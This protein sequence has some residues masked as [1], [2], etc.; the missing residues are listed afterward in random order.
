MSRIRVPRTRMSSLCSDA[1]PRF[2]QAAVGHFTHMTRGKSARIPAAGNNIAENQR[3]DFMARD[4]HKEA[5]AWCGESAAGYC[6]HPRGCAGQ[7]PRPKKPGR[8]AACTA[9]VRYYRG[10]LNRNAGKAVVRNRALH[11]VFFSLATINLA[12]GLAHSKWHLG[13]GLACIEVDLPS[14]RGDRTSRLRARTCARAVAAV[15]EWWWFP[16]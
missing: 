8:V 14:C 7:L 13:A 10:F 2:S 12:R 5:H 6:A 9:S 16:S 3:V 15:Q 11:Q 1:L 4:M